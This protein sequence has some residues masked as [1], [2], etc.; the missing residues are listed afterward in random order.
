MSE[1]LEINVSNKIMNVNIS[2]KAQRVKR[3]EN[4]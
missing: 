4:M 3:E 1:L 2:C